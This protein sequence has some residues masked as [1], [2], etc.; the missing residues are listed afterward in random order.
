MH[1]I[2][3]NIKNVKL[4]ENFTNDDKVFSVIKNKYFKSNIIGIDINQLDG[5]KIK[6]GKAIF[7]SSYGYNDI[8]PYYLYKEQ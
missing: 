4:F 7:G 8:D 2:Q 1:L 6:K 5:Y 3:K